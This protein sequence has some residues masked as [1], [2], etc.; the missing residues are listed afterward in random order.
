[1][2]FSCYGKDGYDNAR[3]IRDGI[4]GIA[5]KELLHREKVYPKTGIPPL[6][7]THEVI[8][9]MW[10]RRCDVTV[11]F[12]TYVHVERE[13]AVNWIEHA[14]IIFNADGKIFN[15]IERN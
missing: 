3:L 10:V 14:N 2:I 8:N 9:T 6:V 4:Y 11:T 5:V 15:E 13:N 7:Q 1:M 12:Y